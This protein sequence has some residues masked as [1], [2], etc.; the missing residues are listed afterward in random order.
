MDLLPALEILIF[1]P[2]FFAAAIPNL[3][4][5]R[6]SINPSSKNH[7]KGS[8]KS[9]KPLMNTVTVAEIVFLSLII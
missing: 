3:K 2:R 7:F 5:A 4:S 9:M 6:I 8:M 1:S